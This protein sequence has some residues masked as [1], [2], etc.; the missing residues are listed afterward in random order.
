MICCVKVL[1][2]VICSPY[3]IEYP[4]T[5]K[6]T[7]AQTYSASRLIIEPELGIFSIIGYYT[8]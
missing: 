8:K 5:S 2:I 4:I 1:M 6:E 3:T 7:K